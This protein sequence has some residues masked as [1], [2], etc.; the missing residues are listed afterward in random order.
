VTRIDPP[1]NATLDIR[2]GDSPVSV[3]VGAG[4]VWVANEADGTVWRI[5]P[6]TN[7]VDR[8]IDVGNAPSGIAVADGVVWVAVQAP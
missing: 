4:G 8:K 7:E 2:V 6:Q 3:A 1:T 5:D